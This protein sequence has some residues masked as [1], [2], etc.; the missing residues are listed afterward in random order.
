MIL[1]TVYRGPSD[2][3]PSSD[4]FYEVVVA[5]REQMGNRPLTV[6]LLYQRHLYRARR[7]AH[8]IL[9]EHQPPTPELAPRP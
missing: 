5:V 4:R 2:T 6:R 9:Q 1:D 8:R 3:I 7:I